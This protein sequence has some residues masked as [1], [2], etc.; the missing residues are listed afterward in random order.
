MRVVLGPGDQDLALG[1]VLLPIL[2]LALAGTVDPV[3]ARAAGFALVWLHQ[4]VAR[5]SNDATPVTTTTTTTTTTTPIEHARDVR[6]RH[7]GSIW[8]WW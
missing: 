6:Q 3:V 5:L 2:L 8:G 1:L 7:C 4:H